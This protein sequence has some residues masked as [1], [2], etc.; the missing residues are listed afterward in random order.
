MQ[1]IECLM[2][3]GWLLS[4]GRS[5]HAFKGIIARSGFDKGSKAR[6]AH[7]LMKTLPGLPAG[8]RTKP[9][10]VLAVTDRC[11]DAEQLQAAI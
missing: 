6:A 8:Q 10:I 5:A 11:V 1:L 7:G 4:R 3:H 9:E 2:F